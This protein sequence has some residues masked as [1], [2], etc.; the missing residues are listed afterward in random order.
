MLETTC[1]VLS[2][3]IEYDALAERHSQTNSEE[4]TQ[5]LGQM[6]AG[7]AMAATEL[8]PTSRAGVAFQ[9]MCMAAEVDTIPAAGTLKSQVKA[10]KHI[11][12]RLA[13]RSLDGMRDEIKKFPNARAYMMPESLD[14]RRV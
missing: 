2:L 4:L 12:N 10:S 9:I 6:M 5:A 8:T 7:F 13:Y 11:V 1:P 14:P 3:A